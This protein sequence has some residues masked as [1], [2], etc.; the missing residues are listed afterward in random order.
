MTE[1]KLAELRAYKPAEVARM[2]NIPITRLEKWVR[3][4]RVPHRRAGVVRG[5]EFTAED[6]R[7]IGSMLPEL[8]G[9]RREPRVAGTR[10]DRAGPEEQAT[11]G[12]VGRQ[13]GGE[14]AS[15]AAPAAPPVVD[16]AAWAQLRAHRPRARST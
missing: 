14:E 1:K 16:I 3:E 7:W 10:D 11:S 6:V 12:E 9:G 8:T 13:S 4:D 15:L 2:L 5:V